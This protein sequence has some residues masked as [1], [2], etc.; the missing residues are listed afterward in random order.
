MN[1]KQWCQ[2][3]EQIYIAEMDERYNQHA[4]LFYRER[5]IERLAEMRA[6][7][8]ETFVNFFSQPRELFLSS[9]ENI[10][11]SSTRKLEL[12]LYN[13]R[14]EKI[15]SS[16]YRFARAPVNWSTWRQFNS[17]EKDPKRR[18]HVFDEFISKTRYISPVIKE[19]FEQ[20]DRIYRKYSDN[21]L[22]PLDGYLE[23][24]KISYSHL[25]DFVKSLGRQARK[26]FQEAL[27][28]IS[29]KVLGRKAEYYDDFYFFRNR[30]YTDLDKEFVGVNPTEQVR[31]T[32]ATMRF[33]LSSI[34]IDTEQRKN[35]YPSPICFFVQVPN[36]IR[37]L[38][39]SESPYF[40]L[41]GC[42][43]EMGHAVHAS[44]ISAEA[45][46]WN[47]YSFSMGIAEIFSI[48]LERLTKNR[49]YLSSLGIK[50]N[51]ILEEIEARNNFMDLFFVT[52][53][54]ANSLMKAKFWHEKLSIEKASDVYARLM[55][56]Y[57]GFEIPG[58]YWMLHHILPDAIMYVPSYLIAAVRA[59]ELDRH[60]QD[61]FGEK[62]WTQ[63]ETGK[64]IR[65]IIQPGAAINLSEFSRLDS[66][67]FMNELTDIGSV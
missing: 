8:A 23:N 30:I 47:R 24:E 20:M 60:L 19:R 46:Y 66:R 34:H 26:P 28:S 33:D 27:Y 9:L 64:Y 58:E 42:Y 43:H 15:I 12:K 35:K 29:K 31:R 32:L 55:K 48:F 40:D 41:Q 5:M 52:F 67:L 36:D 51:H 54:T 61:R 1:L 56:E 4:G 57:T 11:D 2:L 3:D 22:T 49:K 63:V 62:W 65:E 7:S 25:G 21:K 44:S 6:I 59:V 38:Y 18:K 16:R 10:A 37:V 17:I 50:N 45:E 13:L 39:K 53:Y 14:N